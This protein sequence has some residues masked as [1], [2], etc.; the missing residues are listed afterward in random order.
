MN[1]ARTPT[2]FVPQ[3]TLHPGDILKEILTERNW[4]QSDLAER[5][6][7]SPKH[8]NQIVNGS[9]GITGDVAVRLER[10]LGV[11]AVFW[12]RSDAE[13]QAFESTRKSKLALKEHI[14]WARQF[15]LATMRRNEIVHDGDDDATIVDKILKF[16]QVASPDAFEQNWIRRRVSFRRS[17]AFAVELSYQALWL[18]LVERSAE[19]HVDVPSLSL[20]ELRKVSRTLPAMTAM[21]IADGFLAARTALLRAGVVLTFVR[22]VPGTRMNAATWWLDAE[23]PVIG[24]TERHRKPDIFWFNLAHEVGHILKHPR[25]TTFL[26]ID[27]EKA[28]QDPAELEADAFAVETLFPGDARE[29]IARATN[30]QELVLLAAQLGVGVTVVAGNF[31]NQTKDWKLASSL[32]GKITDA[33]ISELENL[34][35]E[36]CS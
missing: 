23:R 24:I 7:L 11:A 2:E 17:Q 3:W 31:A 18:R 5:T 29:R 8:I 4:R 33:D 6:G 12:T 10:A 28:S 34:T 25:R 15:D 32:R 9:I 14:A 36:D 26:D 30:R 21:S 13:Y 20:R 1:A 27:S 19:Q 22:E 16:F 35:A